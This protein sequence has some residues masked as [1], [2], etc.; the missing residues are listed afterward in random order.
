MAKTKA[1]TE[2][3]TRFGIKW[4]MISIIL[5]VVIVSLVI[6]SLIS[7]TMAKSAITKQT[8]LYMQSELKANVNDI[9]SKLETV[10]VTAENLSNF[11][12]DTYT[13]T[14][15]ESYAK[16]FSDIVMSND[17]IL[18]SGIW[19]EP[20]VYTGDEKYSGQEYVG[21]YWYKDGG[22]VVEDW[23]YSNA[24]YDYFAQEYYTNAK[25]MTSLQ[26]VI[27]DPY[28][29]PAS[30]S[31]MASC[32]SPIFDDNGSYIGC[33]T[34]DISL[35]TISDIVAGIKV[36]DA[37]YA[38]LTTADGTYIY[39]TDASKVQ[40][41]MNISEDTDG[42]QSIA[43]TLLS[44]ESGS[45]KFSSSSG[46]FESY[47]GSV[48]EVEWKLLL[49][50]PE[51]EINAPVLNM[52]RVTFIICLI[53]ILLS[54][55]LIVLL[56]SSIAK[57][58]MSV[59]QLAK[60]LASGNFTVDK[61][62]SSRGDEIGEMSRALDEMYRST[63]EIISHISTES[64][65]VNDASTTLSAM[66]EE[67]S[68]EFSK[69]QSNMS[70]VNDAM[71]STGAATEEVSA[72]VQEVNDS[73]QV[74]ADE[75][76][77][78]ETQVAEITERAL[79]IQQKNQIAHDSAINIAYQRRIELE[80][81]NEKAKVVNQISTLAESISAIASQIDL[82]SLNAS[83][84]AARAG[85]AGRGFAVVASEI[86][87]LATETNEAVEKIKDTISSVQEAFN[88]LSDGSNKLL[89][90]VTDT[91]TPDYENF[92]RIGKQYGDDAALFGDLARRMQEMSDSIKNSMRE[93]NDAVQSIAESTQE[94][95]SHSA[96]VTSSVDSV[97]EAVD[98]VAELAM[99]QQ[100]TASN[101]SDI[102]NHFKL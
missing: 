58:L 3:K 98:S 92:V 32:S 21:P 33:I 75:T 11:V 93:V 53:A 97:S 89:A 12:G 31:I 88:D 34:V 47:F 102:V 15:M 41:A 23:E 39:T 17:L 81:A 55:V 40:N 85:D 52:T 84:E 43:S 64:G 62:N 14:D 1:N 10:R 13:T 7:A 71:M 56:A 26:A 24:E 79:D 99:N 28:Y 42:V 70:S 59:D 63:S 82:L 45:A 27:T 57:S 6:V 18:G 78:T 65:N 83:I 19:F 77:Q 67:L 4:R 30:D 96:D 37:G 51:A 61:L 2:S 44:N 90:F 60:E 74:L 69:I 68:A 76:A 50:M 94:T 25:A 91:V 22:S 36:G 46:V 80:A 20:S 35:D 66:S 48:P 54:I 95:A 73:V 8:N 86:N 72:S 49:M 16:I 101:L 38:V 29:D 100:H 87:N 5:P 9:N